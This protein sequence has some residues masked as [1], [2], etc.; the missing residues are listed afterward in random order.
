MGLLFLH[1]QH[2][3]RHFSQG[4]LRHLLFYRHHSDIHTPVLSLA[5]LL[6]QPTVVLPV[7][8]AV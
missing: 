1:R 5:Q 4:R 3:F 6:K 2:L 7:S 8:Q